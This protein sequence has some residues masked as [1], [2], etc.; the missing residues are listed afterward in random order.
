MQVSQIISAL[1][2]IISDK[3]QLQVT[4]AEVMVWI[5]AAMREVA[6]DNEL[7]QSTA[8]STTVVNTGSYSVP[9]DI[10]KLHSV[11]YNNQKL[12]VLSRKEAEEH[13]DN[14][15]TAVGNPAVCYVWAGKI[16]L[17]PA[18]NAANSLVID[19]TRQPVDVTAV[20]NTPELPVQYHNRILD[21]CLA[22]AYLQ[23][24][25][26]NGYN[27]KLAEFTTGVKSIKDTPEWEQDAYPSISVSDRDAGYEFDYG[28]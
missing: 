17:F 19:Y 6:V 3:D 1:R 11:K 12:P 5:N 25:D 18:P 21:Y 22:Q 27:M 14:S 26:L 20:G 23:D 7:L 8:T 4:D 24:G 13:L 16:Y 2:T 28:F 9:T 10:L 15:G